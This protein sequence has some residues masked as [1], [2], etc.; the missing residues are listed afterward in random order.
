M[1]CRYTDSTF[2]LLGRHDHLLSRD[3][4]DG[5]L[6]RRPIQGSFEGFHHCHRKL[7]EPEASGLVLQAL[8]TTIRSGYYHL[9]RTDGANVRLGAIRPRQH[10]HAL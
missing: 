10:D 9:H 7:T 2:G 6:G 1:G 8:I 4:Q 5:V 3:I